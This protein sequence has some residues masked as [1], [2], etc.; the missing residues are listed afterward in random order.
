MTQAEREKIYQQFVDVCGVD[1]QKKMAIE[2]MS[3]LT[4]ELCKSW[5]CEGAEAIE[6]N[7]RNIQEEIADT[8]NMTEQLK[9][10][11]GAEEI[12]RIRDEK[13]QKYAGKLLEKASS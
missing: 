11:Y 9:R 5:R 2:E 10:I 13:L 4:K 1:S 8:L 12:E 3:E 6:A 7:T